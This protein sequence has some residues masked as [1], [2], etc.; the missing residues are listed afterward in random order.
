MDRKPL[1]SPDQP[2]QPNQP[3]HPGQPN[4]PNQ[5]S[6]FPSHRNSHAYPPD[7][8]TQSTAAATLS[9]QADANGTANGDGT[10]NGTGD[11]N[12][13]STPEPNTRKRKAT[14]QPGSRG[15]ANLTPDQLAKKRANDREAQRAIRERTRN[16][17]EGLANRIK[18]LE[19]QQ[20]FQELQ[21]VVAERDRALGECEELRRKLAH[22]ASVVGGGGGGGQAQQGE[23]RGQGQQG[24]Q[25][26][27]RDL[28]GECDVFEELIDV[29]LLTRDG[30]VELAALTAQQSPLPPVSVPA[31]SQYPPPQQ[32]PGAPRPPMYEQQHIHPDLRSPHTGGAQ[33]SPTSQSVSSGTPTYGDSA[34]LRRWSPSLEQPPHPPQ[35]PPANGNSYEQQRLPPRAPMQPQSN[36]ERLDLAYVLEPSPAGPTSAPYH[37]PPASELPLYLRLPKN[38]PPTCPLDSLLLDFLAG[39]RQQIAKGVPVHEVAGPEYPSFLAFKDPDAPQSHGYHPVSAL[40]VDILSKFPDISML[41]EKVAVLYIMFLI[42]RWQIC[43]C[44]RCYQRL[45]TWVKPTTGQMATEHAAWHDHVPWPIIRQRLIASNRVDFEEFFIPFCAK[46]SLNWPHPRDTVLLYNSNASNPEDGVMMNPAFETHLRDLGNWSM[47]TIFR[48]EFPYLIDESVRIQD[49]RRPS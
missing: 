19:S 16:T 23:Q 15:V 29:G 6:S 43:P 35:Y 26:Q 5:P 22:V 1:S 30:G 25:G 27:G 32:S 40:L 45:P 24:Q 2:N 18:E 44:E 21:K 3:T 37:S 11:S 36:G 13:T 12:G 39:R 33:P 8:G 31:G 42:L 48:S 49:G 4:Q 17:L 10:G 20:P 9:S 14:G 47:G 34:N 41:P 46:L 28:H 38:C 7:D